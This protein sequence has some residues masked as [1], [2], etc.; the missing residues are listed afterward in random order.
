MSS[1]SSD[2]LPTKRVPWIEARTCMALA[3]EGVWYN[4]LFR[5]GSLSVD[6]YPQF[7][8]EID[9][10]TDAEMVHLTIHFSGHRM[11][12]ASNDTLHFYDE[13]M[14]EQVETKVA[15]IASDAVVTRCVVENLLIV[16][17]N[18]FRR[19]SQMIIRHGEGKI[20]PLVRVRFA[21]LDQLN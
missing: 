5:I 2:S 17:E 20:A 16:D 11:G 13:N 1:P 21:D 8:L 9:Q 12:A 15:E 6:A 14:F 18:A 4:I 19:L 10:L 7:I 3:N